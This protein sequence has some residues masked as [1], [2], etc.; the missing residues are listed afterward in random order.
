[1]EDIESIYNHTLCDKSFSHE[2]IFHSTT[3]SQTPILARILIL[4]GGFAGVQVLKKLQAE[5]QNYTS[6]EITLVSKDNYFLFTPMLPEVVSGTIE[7]IHIATPVRALCNKRTN[8]YEANVVSIELQNKKVVIMHRVNDNNKTVRTSWHQ[9]GSDVCYHILKYDYLVLALGNETNFFGNANIA[10]NAFT[11]KSLHDAITLRD[12]IIN[13]LEQADLE[14]ENEEH[15]KRLLTF[16]VVGGGFA[17]IETIGEINSFI[18][19]SINNYYHYI[20][21]KD[22]RVIL[23]NAHESILPEVT[24]DL[25]EFAMQKLREEG[26]EVMLSTRVV[27]TDINSVKLGNGSVIL[28][29][30]LIWAG[31]VKPNKFIAELSLCEH[32]KTGRVIVDDYLEVIGHKN[33]SA[34]GDCASIVDSNTGKTCPP[35]AQ[36]AMRQGAVVARNIISDIKRTRR[37]KNR[38]EDNNSKAKFDY[39][40]KGV[41]AKIGKR[42]G[43]G[44]LLGHKVHGFTAWLLWRTYYLANL[45]TFEKKWR[46]TIDWTMDILFEKNNISRLKTFA[47]VNNT[48]SIIDKIQLPLNQKSKNS[49]TV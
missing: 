42:N 21:R 17:G 12:H 37:G 6:V 4:G 19:N 39:K 43:V 22:V 35:T 14:Y 15:L 8:F 20:K 13:M 41:M 26:V 48:R 46:V 45:P 10:N 18:H 25:S 47:E 49:H 27:D 5:F 2:S 3:T 31:G 33:V 32:D 29:N 1:M 24:E 38:R 23:V 40:T 44:I 9:Q 11:I 16:V 7:P 36:H 28:S 34:V 30:T